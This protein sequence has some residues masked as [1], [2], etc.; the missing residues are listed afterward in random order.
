MLPLL[1]LPSPR[2]LSYLPVLPTLLFLP[3]LVAAALLPLL[4][5]FGAGI[6]HAMSVAVTV[7]NTVPPTP[8]LPIP[9][10]AGTG[11]TKLDSSGKGSTAAAAA[12]A[13]CDAL[14]FRGGLLVG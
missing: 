4:L 5:S 9:P 12:A 10:W 11:V 3:L 1:L 14:F 8:L 6:L 2:L 7:A 13:A